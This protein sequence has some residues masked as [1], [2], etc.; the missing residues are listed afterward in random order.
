MGQVGVTYVDPRFYVPARNSS[1]AARPQLFPIKKVQNSSTEST[2]NNDAVYGAIYK[3]VKALAK[4]V[5]EPD[6]IDQ[7]TERDALEWTLRLRDS[8]VPPPKIFSHGGDAV[9]FVWESAD[10]RLYMTPSGQA[11]GLYSVGRAGKLETVFDTSK[12]TDLRRLLI[13]LGGRA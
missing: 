8:Q 1:S 9:T 2:P 6:R 4:E 12:T 5:D 10:R 3:A 13:I 11:V 7:E